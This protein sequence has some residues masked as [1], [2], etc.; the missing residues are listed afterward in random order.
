MIHREFVYLVFADPDL[1]S[2]NVFKR[3]LNEKIFI[4]HIFI[5]KF[6]LFYRD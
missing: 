6:S 5:I 2:R 1:K 3:P 4:S